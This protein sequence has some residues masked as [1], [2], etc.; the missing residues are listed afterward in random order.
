MTVKRKQNH[1][2]IKFL[3]GYGFSIKLYHK[4]ET[5]TKIIIKDNGVGVPKDKFEEVFV[6]FHLI[7]KSTREHDG[8][9]LGLS[10]CKGIIE[11][12]GGKI[13]VE[14]EGKGTEIHILLPLNEQILLA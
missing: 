2:N 7:D 12:H 13:W 10:V 14:L 6:K 3:K 5:N 1:Y 4:Y 8:T 11:S 9:G